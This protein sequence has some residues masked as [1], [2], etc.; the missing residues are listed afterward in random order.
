MCTYFKNTLTPFILLYR[1]MSKYPKDDI[2]HRRLL[3]VDQALSEI[4][5]SPFRVPETF[6][7]SGKKLMATLP[8]TRSSLRAMLLQILRDP[9]F[10][11]SGVLTEGGTYIGMCVVQGSM[12]L[13]LSFSP[14]KTTK[15]S[16]CTNS[17][18][19]IPFPD[20]FLALDSEGVPVSLRSDDATLI[21]NPSLATLDVPTEATK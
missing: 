2:N 12:D 13:P 16:H 4:F 7:E 5:Q 8:P 10:V 18:F 11:V 15:Y 20:H 17:S 1:F 21:R 9:S 19:L 14:I 3:M 6:L